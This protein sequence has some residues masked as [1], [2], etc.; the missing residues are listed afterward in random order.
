M[1]RI[2]KTSQKQLEEDSDQAQKK[3]EALIDAAVDATALCDGRRRVNEFMKFFDTAGPVSANASGS[4]EVETRAAPSKVEEVEMPERF[5]ISSDGGEENA[6][7]INAVTERVRKQVEDFV[8]EHSLD[9]KAKLWSATTGVAE[10]LVEGDMKQVRNPS[11]YISRAV[12]SQ[13]QQNVE[14]QY[15]ATDQ[16]HEAGEENYVSSS[17]PDDEGWYDNSGQDD[18][19][20]VDDVCGTR[21]KATS[22]WNE[23]AV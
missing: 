18:G 7:E 14:W 19:G 23:G 8:V 10:K 17:V 11:A 13:E 21:V 9:A 16:P 6:S 15:G 12:G 4:G 2:A 1:D 3:M 20:G 22:E 5:D